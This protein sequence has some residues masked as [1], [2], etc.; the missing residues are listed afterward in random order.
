MSTDCGKRLRR[1]I[2]LS[3]L[4]PFILPGVTGVCSYPLR[5]PVCFGTDGGRGR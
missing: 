2:Y 5:A 4:P 3:D 1:C